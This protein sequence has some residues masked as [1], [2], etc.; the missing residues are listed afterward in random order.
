[1]SFQDEINLELI[2]TGLS[3][4][5]ALVTLG[6]GWVIGNQLSARVSM[7]WAIRQKKREIELETVSM[8][9]KVYGEFFAVWKL[10]V[11]HKEQSFT[12]TS[13]WEMLERAAT[14]EGI[15]ESIFVK[16]SSERDL[17]E[18]ETEILGRFRQGF[19]TL[20]QSIR[21]DKYLGWSK[22]KYNEYVSFKRLAGL[23]SD[24]LVSETPSKSQRDMTNND[25][26]I[27]ITSNRWE[28][29]W[30]LSDDDWHRLR[31]NK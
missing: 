21:D 13:R 15:L 1:M 19:Q 2:K 24:I 6:L 18:R 22:D 16:L 10:W 26:L 12:E 27:K 8:F 25:A 7:A 30:F 23:V 29:H 20:R 3:L 11:Y 5:V 31:S 17:N 4:L 9:Y 28:K 14:A